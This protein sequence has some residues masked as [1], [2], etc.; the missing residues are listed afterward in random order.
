VRLRLRLRVVVRARVRVRV[1]DDEQR[2]ALNAVHVALELLLRA[3]L[4]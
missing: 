3:W 2:L 1:R 4:G